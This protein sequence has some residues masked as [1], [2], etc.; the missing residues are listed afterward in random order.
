MKNIIFIISILFFILIF[1]YNSALDIQ[2]GF[3][4]I[5]YEQ[6]DDVQE[7]VKEQNQIIVKNDRN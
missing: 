7:N 1:N 5:T 4:Y 6:G 3:G 2:H